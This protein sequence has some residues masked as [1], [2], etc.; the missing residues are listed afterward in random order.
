[1]PYANKEE[2]NE[3]YRKAY[4]VRYWS[5]EEFRK[6]EAERKSRW[7]HADPA[8]REKVRQQVAAWR[9]KKKAEALRKKS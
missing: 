8:R 7:Y 6:A 3:H 4:G 2:R 9:A 1:M 5:D